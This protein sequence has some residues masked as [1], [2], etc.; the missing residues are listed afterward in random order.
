[1]TTRSP[2]RIA[3]LSF[4]FAFATLLLARPASAD[5]VVGQVDEFSDPF[6]T[7]FWERGDN[8][9]G[10]LVLTADGG[11]SNGKLVTFNL[12]QWSG[13]YLAAGVDAIAMDLANP[14]SQEPLFVRLA[15]GDEINPGTPGSTW[16]ATT[17]AVQLVPGQSGSIQF[18]IGEE[19]LTRVQGSASYADVLGDVRALR[20][21]HN[22]E[23]AARGASILG[24]L[25]IDNI[26]ALGATTSAPRAPAAVAAELLPAYPNPFNP[27]TT[28]RFSLPAAASVEL[29]ITDLRGLHVRTLVAGRL[30]AGEHRA[31]WNG[32]DASGQPVASGVYLASLRALGQQQSQR[33]TLVK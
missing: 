10:K 31:T 22:P 27:S 21:L 6:L 26:A 24:F 30:G 14:G 17:S 33:L 23:P 28:V 25:E 29:V 9:D 11:G 8:L 2:H 15:F 20:I 5:V 3:S 19:F 13:D 16:F 12:I 18:A 1:M 7:D 4:V 32:L